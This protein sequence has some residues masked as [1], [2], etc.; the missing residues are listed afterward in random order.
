VKFI[1]QPDQR[2]FVR[3]T[4]PLLIIE[5]DPTRWLFDPKHVVRKRHAG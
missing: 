2:P 4:A 3:P 1:R 5:I